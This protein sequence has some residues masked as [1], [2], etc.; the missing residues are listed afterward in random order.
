MLC[1]GSGRHAFINSNQGNLRKPGLIHD[2]QWQGS[3]CDCAERNVILWHRKDDEAVHSGCSYDLQRLLAPLKK[4]QGETFLGT[5]VGHAAQERG[6]RRIFERAAQRERINHCD[7][8][9]KT[10]AQHSSC[11]IRAAVI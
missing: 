10:G 5:R 3:V 8:P 6:R 2:N 4:K 11:R 1:T 9:G 7:G